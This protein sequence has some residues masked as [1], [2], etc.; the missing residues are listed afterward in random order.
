MYVSMYARMQITIVCILD[1]KNFHKQFYPVAS[2][3]I[4]YKLHFSPL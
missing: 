3:I 1:I 2:F 4:S